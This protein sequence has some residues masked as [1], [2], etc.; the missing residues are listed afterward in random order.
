MRAHNDTGEGHKADPYKAEDDKQPP[1]GSQSLVQLRQETKEQEC[2][3]VS[4]M[5]GREAPEFLHCHTEGSQLVPQC[6]AGLPPGQEKSAGI[7]G[8]ETHPR[9]APGNFDQVDQQHFRQNGK[10]QS[11]RCPKRLLSLC[12]AREN[13]ASQRDSV[14]SS[15]SRIRKNAKASLVSMT[16]FS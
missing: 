16:F 11:G 14:A 9:T 8:N 10:E 12:T 3:S 1:L 13:S 7:R 5:A 2:D 15:T 4:G 6:C